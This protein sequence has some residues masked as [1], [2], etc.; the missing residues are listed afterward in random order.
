[1]HPLT[2]VAL[3]LILLSQSSLPT[4]VRKRSISTPAQIE[5]KEMLQIQI[6][7]TELIAASLDLAQCSLNTDEFILFFYQNKNQ[8][9]LKGTGLS[10]QDTG[11]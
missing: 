9:I 1:M 11:S 2:A 5:T 7:I 3:H 8:Q 10:P 6:N 4:P